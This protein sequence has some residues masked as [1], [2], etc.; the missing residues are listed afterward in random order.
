M[1]VCHRFS[2]WVLSLTFIIMCSGC[3]EL[4]IPVAQIGAGAA[5]TSYGYHERKRRIEEDRQAKLECAKQ[6]D[7]DPDTLFDN[8]KL[9]INN[10]QKAGK[11]FK[12]SMTKVVDDPSIILKG[13]QQ[14]EPIEN[15]EE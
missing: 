9:T 1:V 15:Q 10:L 14:Q 6:P 13:H 2:L 3:V 12:R 4:L 7:C 8:R 5:A 11:K